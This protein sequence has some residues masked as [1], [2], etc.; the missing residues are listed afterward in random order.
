MSYLFDIHF[1]SFFVLRLSDSSEV[2][3]S[4]SSQCF[5]FDSSDAYLT[6]GSHTYPYLLKASLSANVYVWGDVRREGIRGSVRSIS[7][8]WERNGSAILLAWDPLVTKNLLSLAYKLRIFVHFILLSLHSLD[9]SK[10]Y[11]ASAE[12]L[13]TDW[14]TFEIKLFWFSRSSLSS[15]IR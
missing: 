13:H 15:I 3:T 1:K 6:I 4:D 8:D 2:R 12:R 11:N 9:S 10:L 7:S 5:P 14:P